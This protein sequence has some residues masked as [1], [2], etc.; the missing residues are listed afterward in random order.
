[1]ACWRYSVTAARTHWFNQAN[2]IADGAMVKCYFGAEAGQSH[3]LA[4]EAVKVSDVLHAVV[5]AVEADADHAE[6]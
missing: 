1:M 2:V 3:D 5:V 6:D 4:D